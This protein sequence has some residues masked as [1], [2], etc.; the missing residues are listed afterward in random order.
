MQQKQESKF[1]NFSFSTD[2]PQIIE[3]SPV[4]ILSSFG[5][6]VSFNATFR[7]YP[8]NDLSIVWTVTNSYGIL[9]FDEDQ[10]TLHQQSEAD[11]FSSISDVS[12][13]DPRDVG[14]IRCSISNGVGESGIKT[15]TLAIG[16][17]VDFFS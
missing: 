2:A 3:Q 7:A 8:N 14:T 11:M 10:I 16:I 5:N 12:R 4:I 9:T 15:F 1:H 17:Y 6:A 13:I